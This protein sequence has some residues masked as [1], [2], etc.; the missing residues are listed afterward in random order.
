MKSRII[1]FRSHSSLI[2][3]SFAWFP[4]SLLHHQPYLLFLYVRERWQILGWTE[5][6]M[7]IHPRLSC[8]LPHLV[9]LPPLVFQY[10]FFLF[11]GVLGSLA[12]PLSY[13]RRQAGVTGKQHASL[14]VWVKWSGPGTFNPCRITNA[15]WNLFLA[16]Y[17]PRGNLGAHHIA[18]SSDKCAFI[19]PHGFQKPTAL[20]YV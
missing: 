17:Q 16:L 13:R 9:S 20:G 6:T 3:L 12:F 18:D 8:C 1:L 7:S 2:N 19:C 14:P 15:F 11:S 5:T 4:S 10:F